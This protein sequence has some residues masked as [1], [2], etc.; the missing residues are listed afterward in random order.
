MKTK[1]KE[2]LI[3]NYDEIS[4]YC[5]ETGEPVLIMDDDLV[6]MSIDT[7]QDF[8]IKEKLLEIKLARENGSKGHSIEELDKELKDNLNR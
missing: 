6:V 1:T 4:T 7:Y 2:D 5:N 3:N 8:G